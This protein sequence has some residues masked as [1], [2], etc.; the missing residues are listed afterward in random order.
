MK[1][2]FTVAAL[3]LLAQAALA[4]PALALDVK[5]T[6]RLD[7]PIERVWERIGA[8]CAIGTWHPAVEGCTLRQDGKATERSIALKGGGTIEERLQAASP[9]KHSIRY[10]LLSGPLPVTDYVSTI[11]LT[12]LDAKT[13]RIVWSAHFKAKGASDAEARKAIAGIYTSGF[14]GLRRNLAGQAVP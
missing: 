7:A 3:A 5:E 8:F 6:A 11:R 13:T 14:D 1:T 10:G 4:L 12:A 9:A 2:L